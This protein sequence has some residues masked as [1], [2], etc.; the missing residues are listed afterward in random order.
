MSFGEYL[1]RSSALFFIVFFFFKLN[2]TSCLY[3]VEINPLSAA[4]FAKIFSHSEV[5]LFILFMVSC[6]MQ[7]LLSFI[8]SDSLFFLFSLFQG[9][10]QKISCCDL[11]QSVLPIFPSKSFLAP[12]LTFTSLIH[13]EF[14]FV[15]N[16][17]K[18]SNFILLHVAA[19]FSQ[20]Y[21]L[22]RLSFLH[23]I[24]LTPLS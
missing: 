1:F 21:S 16:I 5:C 22:K 12:G 13:F 18:Y 24:F 2:C 4:S 15:H 14:I 20:H 3:I 23:C 7:K 11:C 6:A 9:V 17:S 19:Q 10:G 8:R